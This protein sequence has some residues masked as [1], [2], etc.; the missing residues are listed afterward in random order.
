MIDGLGNIQLLVQLIKLFAGY[1][2]NRLAS[3]RLRPSDE[4]IFFSKTWK[5]IKK[6]LASE[7]IEHTH[8]E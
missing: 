4:F 6:I 7:S 2:P 3:P 8:T 1:K 5:K